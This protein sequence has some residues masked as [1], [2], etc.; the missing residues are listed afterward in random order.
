MATKD[1]SESAT[2]SFRLGGALLTTLEAKALD[3]QQSRGELAR[4][5]VLSVLQDEN[6]LQLMDEVARLQAAAS[7]LRADVATTLEVV[8]INLAGKDPAVVKEFVRKHLRERE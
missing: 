2:V 3:R 1:S 4:S 6:H 7:D 8:L 5:L